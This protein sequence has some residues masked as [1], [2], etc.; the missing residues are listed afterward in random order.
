VGAAPASAWT[1]R[2][3]HWVEHEAVVSDQSRW[4]IDCERDRLGAILAQIER[5]ERRLASTTA[6]DV[7]VRALRG[8]PGIGPV[9][10]W[11]LRAEIGRFDRF[12]TGKQLA[13]FCGLSPRN[14]S[15]GSRVADA[16]LIQAGNRALRATLIEAAHRLIR[17]TAYWHDWAEMRL[18]AGKP[19]CVVIA[20]VANR[21]VRWLYHQMQPDRLAG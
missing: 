15:S 3:W 12:R 19:K 18:V 16:G 4:I 17:Q 6:D 7:L 11:T 5:V 1:R 9:T 13:R 20:A 21:W 10:S 2:W 8:Q 14:A